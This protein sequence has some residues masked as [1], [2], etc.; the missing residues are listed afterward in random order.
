MF[1]KQSLFSDEWCS[2]SYCPTNWRVFLFYY[3][4]CQGDLVSAKHHYT[5]ASRLSPN[6]QLINNNLN[7]LLA[8][9]AANQPRRRRSRLMAA[10]STAASFD[11][12]NECQ[13]PLGTCIDG[14]MTSVSSGVGD[15]NNFT[16]NP[17]QQTTA[18]STVENHRRCL[19]LARLET[20]TE[21][22]RD[23]VT[24]RPLGYST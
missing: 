16:C 2:V 4:Y 13:P 9:M 18:L 14:V 7:K 8:Q 19:G 10:R 20:K 21:M 23:H 24:T 1:P 15:L 3:D 5:L 11:Q 17:P 22:W 12:K 6:D